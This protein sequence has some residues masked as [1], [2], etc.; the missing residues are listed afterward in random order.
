[1]DP[2]L[3]DKII[4]GDSA[5]EI[6]DFIKDTLFGKASEKIDALKPG[7]ANQLFGN[8]ENSEEEITPDG[9]E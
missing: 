7:V 6:S 4:S 5:A 3:V 2:T 9:E 8:T 1:M